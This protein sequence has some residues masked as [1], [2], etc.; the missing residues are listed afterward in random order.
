VSSWVVVE[1]LSNPESHAGRR[2]QEPTSPRYRRFEV[3]RGD[4]TLTLVGY[5]SPTPTCAYPTLVD[6]TVLG[7][8]ETSSRAGLR[9][10][11]RAR[12]APLICTGVVVWLSLANMNDT[13][14]AADVVGTRLP[15]RGR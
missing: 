1:I 3:K 7:K 10:R 9:A 12:R 11:Y 4:F 5:F 14:P 6:V 13:L 15:T 8:K 2:S